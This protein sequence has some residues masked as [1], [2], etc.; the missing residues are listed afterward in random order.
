MQFATITTVGYGDIVPVRVWLS[1]LA[2]RLARLQQVSHVVHAAPPPPHGCV[3]AATQRTNPERVFVIVAVTVGATM[4]G[5][6]IGSVTALVDTLTDS[7]ARED[8]RMKEVSE[9]LKYGQLFAKQHPLPLT[10]ALWA[11]PLT[12]L[13]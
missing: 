10:A 9:Y 6:V 8:L 2:C 11:F 13:R 5:F 1:W 7:S 12:G 4:F 3:R